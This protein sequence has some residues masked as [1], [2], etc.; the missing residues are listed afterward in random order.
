[1]PHP[2]VHFEVIGRDAK[3]SQDF[4]A[5]LFDWQIDADN[6]YNYGMVR[7][8]GAGINGGVGGGEQ[9]QT[10]FYVEVPD[11]QATLDK[12]TALGGKVVMP[13]TEIPGAVTMAQFA[14]RDGN[15]VGLIKG[16]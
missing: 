7:N 12:A 15:V 5:Q 9:P 8:G 3:A 10:L 16:M 1:M 2:V 13:V 6:P 4:Y 11:L 14:D